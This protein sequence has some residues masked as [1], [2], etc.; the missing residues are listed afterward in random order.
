MVDRVAGVS[1]DDVPEIKALL[2]E[3][4]RTYSI[5]SESMEDRFVEIK[6]G[7]LNQLLARSHHVIQGRRGTGKSTVMNVLLYK[8]QAD[9]VP[10]R[11]CLSSLV[12][13]VHKSSEEGA[14]VTTGPFSLLPGDHLHMKFRSGGV[15]T[16]AMLDPTSRSVVD[17]SPAPAPPAE[18]RSG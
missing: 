2:A 10:L 4:R 8:A 14:S 7:L 6:P 5:G 16:A 17:P 9:G 1:L 3:A 18:R 13:A 11:S 12:V 15:D